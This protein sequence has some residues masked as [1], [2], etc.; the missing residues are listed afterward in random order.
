MEKI[1]Q[2]REYEYNKLTKLA[3][4]NEQQINEKAISL[5]EEK[6]VAEITVK[7][8]VKE[9]WYSERSIKCRSSLFYRD[10][11]FQIPED[12]RLRF[13]EIIKDYVSEIAEEEIGEPVKNMNNLNR[14]YK[15]LAY[16]KYIMC[17]IAA[18]GW[19]A[20]ITYLCVNKI[21]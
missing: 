4:L 8:Y 14:E 5:W 10:E 2:L 19:V 20:F 15:A 13:S 3:M 18:S 7:L 9:D 21:I 16:F 6:G 11:K 1:V 17:A 12:V